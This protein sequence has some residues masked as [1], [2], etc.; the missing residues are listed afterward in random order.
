[1][2]SLSESHVFAPSGLINRVNSFKH[3]GEI[4]ILSYTL[5]LING[6]GFKIKVSRSSF[7]RY[8]PW[9]ERIPS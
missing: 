4:P 9:E 3:F 8:R 2:S 7:F 6:N 1:M 5:D